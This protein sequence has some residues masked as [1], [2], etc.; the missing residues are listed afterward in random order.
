MIV[1]AMREGGSVLRETYSFWRDSVA[2]D[3]YNGL[4]FAE[5][6]GSRKMRYDL[7]GV[8]VVIVVDLR[9]VRDALDFAIPSVCCAS[10]PKS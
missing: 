5:R 7:P 6:I 8:V 3:Q 2:N 10:G 1:G 4:R 9:K